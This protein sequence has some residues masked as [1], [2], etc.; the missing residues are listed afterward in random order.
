MGRQYTCESKSVRVTLMDLKKV[1]YTNEPFILTHQAS[2]IFYVNDPSNDKWARRS[3]HKIHDD[4]CINMH[5]TS[6]FSS[7]TLPVK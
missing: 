5:E 7:R 3:M 6:S 1:G 4:E 2:Q